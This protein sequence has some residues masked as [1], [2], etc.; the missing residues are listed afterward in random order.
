MAAERKQDVVITGG[1]IPTRSER[2]PE[3]RIV[4]EMDGKDL[5]I[6]CKWLFEVIL[7]PIDGTGM[8]IYLEQER[9]GQTVTNDGQYAVTVLK[10]RNVQKCIDLDWTV[11]D[12]DEQSTTILL[13]SPDNQ[14]FRMQVRI[15]TQH[16][17][18][19]NAN[20]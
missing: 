10:P 19:K 2:L 8:F 13:D 14:A 6:W 17:W 4:V 9:A 3:Q 11:S 5:T 20:A 7:H 18:L 16:P 15:P 12:I 1:H